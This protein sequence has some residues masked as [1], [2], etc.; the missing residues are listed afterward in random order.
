MVFTF[1]DFCA[2]IWCW[3]LGLEMAWFQCVAFS[4][5]DAKAEKTYRMF[6]WEEESNFWDLMKINTSELPD[7]DMLIA[8][9]PCQT[10][11]I[12]WQRN[13]M[14][15]PRGQVIY[16]I[17]KILK[18]KNIKYFLLE[19]VKWLVNHERGDTIKNIVKLLND[20]G[21]YVNWKVLNTADYLLPQSRERVY[22][23][24]MRKDLGE[25][26]FDFVFPAKTWKDSLEKYLIEQSDTYILSDKKIET[27]TYYLNNAY[28]KGK[29]TVKDLE[30]MSKCI[31][32]TR[33]SDVRIYKDVCP[34]L[35]TGRHW[36]IYPRNW[37][38]RDI[39]GI[40]GLL[41]QGIPLNIAEK[42][43]WKVSDTD[44]LAQAWNAMSVNVISEIG[45]QFRTFILWN[46]LNARLGTAW[47][48]NSKALI[49]EW[50]G[51]N[52]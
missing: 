21:Y 13:W 4:E 17:A 29:Y 51:R 24:G 23:M 47:V 34:T 11:S 14:E 26:S 40:E 28:N 38:L 48:S 39:S 41:L 43:R 36:L 18:E 12:M 10:F 7:I 3:R 37:K 45:K 22:F 8:G 42:A 19:N 25:L 16:G 5:I 30:K 2:G 33:Q 44:L 49:S 52:R 27:L 9:F 15:D 6:F 20:I 46:H 35:R 1:M 50:A 31:I 32:D